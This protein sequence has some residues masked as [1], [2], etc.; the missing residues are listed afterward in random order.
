MAETGGANIE[1]AHHLNESKSPG[2]ERSLAHEIVEIVEAIVL[3]LV[4]ITTAWSGYQSALWDGQQSQLYGRATKLRVE[5]QGVNLAS[6]QER[7]YNASTVA[8]WLKAEAE[9]N[10]KLADIFERRLLPEFRPAFAAWKKTDPV[11]NPDAPAGPA[12]MPEYRET[13]ATEGARLTREADEIFGKGTAD[14]E[15]AEKYVRV[16]VILATVLLL[17]AISSRFHSHIIRV[18]LVAIAFLLLCIPLWS[19]FNL[20]RAYP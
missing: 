14:R 9:G 6:N 20:P 2:E 15:V 10:T 13:K 3:A 17:T 5:A 1:V 16:T 4:A 18:G 11:H 7:I 19:I 12:L 8:E